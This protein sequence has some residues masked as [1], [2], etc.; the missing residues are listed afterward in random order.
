M[1]KNARKVAQAAAGVVQEF[2]ARRRILLQIVLLVKRFFSLV[3]LRIIYLAN[4]YHSNYLG[5]IE[6]DNVYITPY[7]RRIEARRRARGSA[8]LMPLKKL[9]RVKIIDPFAMKQ[10][11]YERRNLLGQT[12]KL[13]LEVMTTST[14]VLLDKMLYEVLDTVRNH[15]QLEITQ[16]R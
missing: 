15:G 2:E 3:F 5:D 1:E 16:V 13:L 14:F 10:S 11:R 6:Y 9:E 7:F 8:T 12:A 4:N